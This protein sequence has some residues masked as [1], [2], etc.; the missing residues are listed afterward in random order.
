M[1]KYQ[2]KSLKIDIDPYQVCHRSTFSLNPLRAS[3]PYS[4]MPKNGAPSVKGK[5]ISRISTKLRDSVSLSRESSMG[6]KMKTLD[7]SHLQGVGGNIMTN[8]STNYTTDNNST[9][10]NIRK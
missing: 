6:N 2:N 1:S 10:I 4:F 8:K 3:Q 9:P 7:F 5:V